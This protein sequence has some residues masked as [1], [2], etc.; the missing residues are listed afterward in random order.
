VFVGTVV[1]PAVQKFKVAM[2]IETGGMSMV[3]KIDENHSVFMV[4]RKTSLAQF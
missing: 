2:N 4:Y 1:E 3:Y